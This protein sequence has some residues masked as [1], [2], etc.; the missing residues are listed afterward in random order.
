VFG[1]AAISR[2]PELKF[3]ALDAQGESPG[4]FFDGILSTRIEWLP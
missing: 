3:S 4:R 1:Y 2:F